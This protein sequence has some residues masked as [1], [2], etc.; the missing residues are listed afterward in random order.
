[1]DHT[2]NAHEAFVLA[3]KIASLKEHAQVDVDHLL[4]AILSEPNC[5]AVKA[6]DTLGVPINTLRDEIEHQY[7]PTTKNIFIPLRHSFELVRLTTYAFTVAEL[8]DCRIS[9]KLLVGLMSKLN[10]ID[11]PSFRVSPEDL[12][13]EDLLT[14]SA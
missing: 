2:I 14:L 13:P 5:G 3:M 10:M 1:M 11:L 4:L 8:L 12:V 9:T 7:K 6:L